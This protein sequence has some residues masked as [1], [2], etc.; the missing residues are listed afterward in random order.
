MTIDRTCSGTVPDV[1]SGREHPRR[2][3]MSESYTR[4]TRSNSWRRAFGSWLWSR[5]RKPGCKNFPSVAPTFDQCSR[6]DP[7]DGRS[8]AGVLSNQ[9]ASRLLACRRPRLQGPG[10][11][12]LANADG[13][14]RVG[15]RLYLLAEAPS[16]PS[17]S[18]LSLFAFLL[19]K[20]ASSVKFDA[21]A[22]IHIGSRRS[23]D[24]RKGAVF[25]L[26]G[27]TADR[28]MGNL[29]ALGVMAS[30]RDLSC[31]STSAATHVRAF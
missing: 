11:Y 12:P 2:N 14:T 13:T 15:G 16:H 22:P 29:P 10:T 3:P 18:L 6:R 30:L 21:F 1:L 24:N 17:G 7:R 25:G 9:R 4:L 5:V 19:F 20:P 31:V 23:S 28:R 27:E 8:A 26:I